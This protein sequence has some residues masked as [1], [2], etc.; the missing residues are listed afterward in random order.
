MILPK[1]NNSARL[2]DFPM[3]SVSIRL[4]VGIIPS[5]LNLIHLEPNVGF[6]KNLLFLQLRASQAQFGII[7]QNERGRHALR[8]LE[9]DLSF[10][11]AIKQQ[12]ELTP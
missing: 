7:R 12:H 2:I 5:T 8:V 6:L 10:A 9:C 4:R 3:S 11:I 1:M